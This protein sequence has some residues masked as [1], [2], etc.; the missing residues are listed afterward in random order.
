MNSGDLGNLTS[1]GND[2]RREEHMALYFFM[3]IPVFVIIIL[4][5]F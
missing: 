4:R 1:Y 5:V 3:A 2:N